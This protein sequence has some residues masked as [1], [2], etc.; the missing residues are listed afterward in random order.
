MYKI[1]QAYALLNVR[2]A[3]AG[4]KRQKWVLLLSI[5]KE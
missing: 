2:R 5:F 1:A 4:A 3:G